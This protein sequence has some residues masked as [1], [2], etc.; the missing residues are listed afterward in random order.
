MRRARCACGQGKPLIARRIQSY[1]LCHLFGRNLGW[2]LPHTPRE[3]TQ[4]RAP[5]AG[6][7]RPG[8]LAR[9]AVVKQFTAPGQVFATVLVEI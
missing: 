4:S 9:D 3:G 6:G 2:L 5:T 7:G 1:L 8:A